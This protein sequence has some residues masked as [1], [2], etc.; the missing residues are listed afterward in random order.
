[1]DN[2]VVIGTK[3]NT[4]GVDKGI[5]EIK[6]KFEEL[7]D[8]EVD[9]DDDLILEGM[10][11]RLQEL[12]EELKELEKKHVIGDDE[13]R[14]M[15]EIK[16]EI[17][18]I[19]NLANEMTGQNYVFKGITDIDDTLPSINNKLNTMSKGLERM[20]KKVAHLGLKLLGIR[21]VYGMIS[22]SVSRVSNNN[23]EIKASMDAI[24]NVLDGIIEQ[25]LIALLPVIQ[26]ITKAIQYIA[27]G[28]FGIDVS[29]NN[30][31]KNIKSANGTVSKLRKQ[32]MGFDEMNIL[33]KDT[34]TTGA[35]GGTLNVNTPT[36]VNLE[37]IKKKIQDWFDRNGININLDYV[38]GATKDPL[39][40]ITTAWNEMIL[41]NLLSGPASAIGLIFGH[42]STITK[43]I[44]T[45]FK[46]IN[47]IAKGISIWEWFF[48]N[49][50]QGTI[51]DLK[52]LVKKT[53]STSKELVSQIKDKVASS[54]VVF[55][56][57][58]VELHTKT[59][60]VIKMTHTD[61]EELMN[62]LGLK[63]KD[64]GDNITGVMNAVKG[65]L[66]QSNA[67]IAQAV[68]DGNYKIK[69]GYVEI[70]TASGET[71]KYSMEQFKELQHQLYDVATTADTTS[72]K[73]GAIN[74][75]AKKGAD[76]AIQTI[77]EVFANYNAPDVDVNVNENSKE[78]T[79]N[80]T[81][82]VNNYNPP[83]KTVKVNADTSKFETAITNAAKNAAMTGIMVANEFKWN[84]GGKKGAKGLLLNLPRLASGGI[85]S[86]PGRGVPLALGG[87]IAGE[88]GREAVLPLTDS[89][90]MEYLGREIAKHI[91][92]NL[93]NVTEL[94][95][96][97]IARSVTQVLSDMNFASNGGV[98]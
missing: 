16:D 3:V 76:L 55:N 44:Q 38:E 23:E 79:D 9:V 91:V 96:R 97:Q 35:L 18:S 41:P 78:T 12:D 25:V 47:P 53:D 6:R 26:I 34:G 92:V 39:K 74:N 58:L 77:N 51:K 48:G 80:I 19:I 45:I 95:G 1:M 36:D 20:G 24:N 90:Q 13:R 66:I 89:Q 65:G 63:A 64:T 54:A 22:S 88:R 69:N 11:D 84:S 33:N 30:F 71:V 37:N 70:K 75:G 94:D 87:A 5:T 4:E 85:I 21:S 59:G 68:L 7:D 31:K 56:N 2:N 15:Q 67:E 98:I 32:L 46:K 72:D 8:I 28:L 81:K 62:T 60:E 61:Y 43:T 50:K 29:S 83:T 17:T 49:G 57:G 86:R 42:D 14:R 73:L 82:T 27:Q 52:D 93:T 40:Y 10:T